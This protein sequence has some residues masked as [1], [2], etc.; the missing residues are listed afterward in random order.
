M[1]LGL[2]DQDPDLLV[3]GTDPVPNPS[4]IKQNSKTNLLFFILFLKNDVK[5]KVKVISRKTYKKK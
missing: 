2:L 3:R 1:F 4:L 5:V